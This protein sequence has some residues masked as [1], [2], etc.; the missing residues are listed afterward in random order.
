[1]VAT[2]QPPSDDVLKN[3]AEALQQKHNFRYP[4]PQLMAKRIPQPA[5]DNAELLTDDF[6]PV[7]LYDADRPRTAE[8]EIITPSAAPCADRLRWRRGPAPSWWRTCHSPSAA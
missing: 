8:A 1:M 6:A 7:N 4:L 5:L 2:A 3:R